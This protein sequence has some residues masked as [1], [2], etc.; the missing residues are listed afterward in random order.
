LEQ[1]PADSQLRVLIAVAKMDEVRS[2]DV[3]SKGAATKPCSPALL[4]ATIQRL[5][6][7]R[8]R[9]TRTH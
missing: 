4:V 5:L 6:I 3:A 1:R 9:S 2:K 7:K 8:V